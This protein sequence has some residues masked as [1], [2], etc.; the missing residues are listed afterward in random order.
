MNKL[1]VSDCSPLTSNGDIGGVINGHRNSINV[2]DILNLYGKVGS[3]SFEE[4]SQLKQKTVELKKNQQFFSVC[5]GRADIFVLR[6]GWASLSHAA[7]ARGQDICNV[8]MPGDVIGL[9]ESFFENH[10]V[11]IHSVTD[12]EFLKVSAEGLHKLFKNNDEIRNAI[13]SYVMINDNIT[14]ERLRSCTHHRSEGRVAHFLLEIYFR[15][16]FKGLLEGDVFDFSITQEVVGELLGI[17]S[18]H[19]SRCMTALEQ[20]KYIRK[21]RNSIKLLEPE[22][23]ARNT[24]FDRDFIYGCVCLN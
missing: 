20:K 1:A 3:S 19:V 11:V 23:M 13:I 2:A 24:G 9:R 21:T 6:E 10:D 7:G 8:F 16:D 22:E 15:F 12:C 4:L 17:T 18:V 5:E 14:L